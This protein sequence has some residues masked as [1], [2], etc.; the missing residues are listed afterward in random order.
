MQADFTVGDC[1]IGETN[2]GLENYGFEAAFLGMSRFNDDVAVQVYEHAGSL[3][4]TDGLSI[5]LNI[6]D[7]LNAEAIRADEAN[8]MYELVS[9][10]LRL[11]LTYAGGATATLSMFHTCPQSP[12]VY[13]NSGTLQFDVLR[14]VIDP[15]DTGRNERI[16][17]T[18]TSTVVRGATLESVGSLQADFRFDVP[19]RPLMTFR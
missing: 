17:G 16:E 1:P 13:A 14:L 2:S 4:D 10:P 11:P 9:S 7:L 5:R 3:E 12:A 15:D 6:A 19:K 8:G 18:M